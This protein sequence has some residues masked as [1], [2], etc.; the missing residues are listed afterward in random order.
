[1]DE[2]STRRAQEQIDKAKRAAAT[3]VGSPAMQAAIAS[4]AKMQKAMAA[5]AA[6]IVIPKMPDYSHLAALRAPIAKVNDAGYAS[7]MFDRLSQQVADF[8]ST[9]DPD[10]EIAAY[11]SSFGARILVQIERI[12]YHNPYLIIFHGTMVDEGHRVRLVQHVTQT[13]VLLTAVKVVE[14]RKPHRVGFYMEAPEE[15]AGTED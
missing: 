7:T 15:D 8:E 9:L 11:L 2:D 10:E 5:A 14:D 3:V 4:Q 6:Q 12:G 1:M 13:S